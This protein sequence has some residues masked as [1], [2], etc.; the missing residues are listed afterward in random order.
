[1]LSKIVPKSW[2][3]WRC[4][5]P[6]QFSPSYCQSNFCLIAHCQFGLNC[7]LC[8]CPDSRSNGPVKKECYC[9]VL[10]RNNGQNAPKIKW[11]WGIWW[12]LY[13]NTI[14]NRPAPAPR[15]AMNKGPC[16]SGTLCHVIQRTMLENKEKSWKVFWTIQTYVLE[17]GSDLWHEICKQDMFRNQTY[18]R[19]RHDSR[20]LCVASMHVNSCKLFCV[21]I[22]G[23][24]Q[25]RVL[26]MSFFSR[27]C[28]A[29]ISLRKNRSFCY[30]VNSERSRMRMVHHG[31]GAME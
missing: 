9:N 2:L 21:T 22:A 27:P 15:H 29:C 17:L 23:S 18:T 12:I 31:F 16:V 28:I 25:F 3:C 4:D 20:V 13:T 1:M 19:A 6:I 7:I 10:A 24:C 30:K 5:N 11:T 14:A 26:L 8:S